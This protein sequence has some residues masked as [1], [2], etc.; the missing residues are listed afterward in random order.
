MKSIKHLALFA[1]LCTAATAQAQLKNAF[2]GR[3]TRILFL[4]DGSG[5][6]VAEM[7]SSH[8]WA[9]AV[10]LMSKLMD[11]V[12]TV[13]NLEVALRVFG[14]NKPITAR[15]CYDTKLEVPFAPNN[16][17]QFINRM[18]AIKPL[19]FTSI[20]Q[21]LLAAA[22]DFPPD[23]TARNMIIIITDGIEECPGDPCAVSEELQKKG[24]I[25]RPFIIGLGTDDDKFRKT[26]SCAGRY[27][28]AQN[29][30]EFQKAIG[31]IISQ[32]LNNTSAQINLLDA[33]GMPRETNV[34]IT[35]YDAGSGAILENWV[36]TMNGKNNPDTLYLDPIR[37]Y[38]IVVHTTP[39]VVKDN[40]E[41]I[42][43][44]HNT[45]PIET[46]QGDLALKI[47][48]I[49]KYGRLPCIVRKKGD[50]NT[51]N[52]QD[53]NTTKRYLTGS[54]DLEILCTPRIL[55]PNVTL[56]QNQTYTV[57][58]PAPGTLQL[59]VVRDVTAA[60]FVIR[61]GKME[62]VMDVDG[63]K[64]TQYLTLQPGDYKMLYRA[65]GETRTMYSKVKDFKITT[66]SNTVLSL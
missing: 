29:E 6:M 25:L 10:N 27:Y 57:E 59:G 15:D 28:N 12:R 65:K 36:H 8:R 46:P 48:G 20:T 53:F 11:T 9:V 45:I 63:S 24:I 47:G 34:P 33:Q 18:R 3:K 32:A 31:V 22:K 49:T 52:V 50:M 7:G 56:R 30:E 51:Q 2:P 60:V 21:S 5:S 35:I 44:R 1:L 16:H 38:R 19:G 64:T 14:H 37:K 41:I 55:I 4:V 39:Q 43:G 13:E 66:G 58:I 62:W 54:Y 26:Y 42:P 61:D 40:V 23:K 17:K